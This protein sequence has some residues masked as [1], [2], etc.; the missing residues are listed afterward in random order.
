MINNGIKIL[1]SQVLF[2]LPIKIKIL[3]IKLDHLGDFILAIPALM[4]LKDKFKFADMDIIVGSW[5]IDLAKELGIFQNIYT[6]DYYKEKSAQEPQREASKEEELLS[7]LTQ[8]DLAIDLRRQPE[9]RFLL[10]KV[11]A[12]L[13]VG[14]TSFSDYDKE[15]D[16]CLRSER[17]QLRVS[18]EM[19]NTSMTLQLLKLVDAIPFQILE[20][21]HSHSFRNDSDCIAIFPFAGNNIK[22]W[23]LEY[24]LLL[25]EEII[26]RKLAQKVNL[27][28]SAK[29]SS[30]INNLT[31]NDSIKINTN[32][33]MKELLE[34]LKDN[35]LTITNN[36]FGAHI[37][38]YLRIPIIGIYGGFEKVEEWQAPFNLNTY[39]YS[40]LDCSPC[41][42]PSIDKCPYDM[43]CL[44]QITL[45]TVIGV[46]E[47]NINHRREKSV[48]LGYINKS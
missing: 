29:D 30:R 33:G 10:A 23:P 17:D 36:S 43:I 18:T 14:Y 16:I 28:I 44:K 37:S 35:F 9:T 3:I 40:D 6:F 12:Q 7:N 1:E 15:I 13:K 39:I 34:S 21:P 38:S 5:N 45:N 41:H 19:N 31:L 20:S 26:N 46:I 2:N 11:N 32:L 24:Y 25:A 4:R 22:E 8:Y 27:Y 47:K 42:I 48:Y